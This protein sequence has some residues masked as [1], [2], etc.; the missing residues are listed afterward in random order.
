MSSKKLARLKLE[1]Q[2]CFAL[3]SASL[4]MTKAYQPLLQ[5]LGLTYSQF[6][7]LSVL[8]TSDHLTVS[9]IGNCLFLD[10]G[11]LTPL[12]KKLEIAGFIKRQRSLTDERQV[13][14]SLTQR[15]QN[16]QKKAAEFPDSLLAACKCL[17]EDG[18]ILIEKISAIRNS[19]IENNNRLSNTKTKTNTNPKPKEDLWQ[20]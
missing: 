7:V 12:L 10:S 6:L 8:W 19:I 4:A 20:K 9:A 2:L 5:P 17:P 18:Q 11:T 13:L 1:N 3:Y 16:V 14:I 15:G